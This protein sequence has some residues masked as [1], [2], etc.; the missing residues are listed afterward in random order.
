M[1]AGVRVRVSVLGLDV[2]DK[3]PLT[4][5]PGLKTRQDKTRRDVTKQDKT[6][7]DMAELKIHF[8][9]RALP[10]FIK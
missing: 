4:G 8:L 5:S 9:M 10:I 6:R 3:K 2:I 7:Q 1:G